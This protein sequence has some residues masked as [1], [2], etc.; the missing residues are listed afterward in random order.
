[1][2][3]KQHTLPWNER[4]T[5]LLVGPMDLMS[6]F[7]RRQYLSVLRKPEYKTLVHIVDTPMELQQY[8]KLVGQHRAVLSLPGRG[9]DC[10]RT[11]EALALG[12]V[13]LVFKDPVYDQR[14]FAQSG[15]QYIPALDDLTVR[16]LGRAM[17]KVQ[18]PGRHSDRLLVSTWADNWRSR[19]D[20]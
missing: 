10:P 1:M 12:T 15:A 11:W 19:F 20:E 17:T 18:D 6:N 3:A 7:L 8:L 16:S 5:K 13:P 9:Y 4:S 2:K 14:L